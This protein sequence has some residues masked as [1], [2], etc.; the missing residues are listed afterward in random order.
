MGENNAAINRCTRMDKDVAFAAAAIYEQMY[1]N[2]EGHV[3]ATFQ[4]INFVAWK[5]DPSQP[6]SLRPGSA[7]V[8]LKDLEN[9]EEIIKQKGTLEKNSKDQD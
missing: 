1:G 2:D 9:I 5:P 3:R 7:D 4:I 6:K 8:S